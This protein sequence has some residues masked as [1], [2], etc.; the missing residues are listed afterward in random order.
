MNLILKQTLGGILLASLLAC[1]MGGKNPLSKVI[2][3]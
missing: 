2:V 1:E 3:F